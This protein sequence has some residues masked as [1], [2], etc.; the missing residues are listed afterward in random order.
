MRMFDIQ[1]IEIMAPRRKVFEF[2]RELVRT[3]TRL[4]QFDCA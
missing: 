2:L 3:V 1:G 4:A